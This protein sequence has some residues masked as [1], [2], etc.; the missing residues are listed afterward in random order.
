MALATLED[1]D[2][3]INVLY[4]GEGGSGKT[5]EAAYMALL[6]KIIMV[7]TESGIKKRPLRRLGLPIENI[8]PFRPMNYADVDKLYWQVKANL[9]KFEVGDPA[10]I[11]GVVFDSYTDLQKKFTDSV[12]ETRVGRQAATMVTDEFDIELKDHGKVTEQCRRIARRFR[13]LDCHTVF[14]TLAKRE[15]DTDGVI[16]RPD[17]TPKFAADMMGY[18]DAAIYTSQVDTP[19]Y[20][21]PSRFLGVTRPIGRYR[22]KDRYGALP[23]VFANPTFDR[24]LEYIQFEGEGGYQ[25]RQEIDQFQQA[26]LARGKPFLST[27]SAPIV[28]VEA[29]GET[30]PVADPEESK[31]VMPAI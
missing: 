9:D 10:R 29:S 23:P 26:Y 14:V 31:A 25:E 1:T 11:V 19:D 24:V 4:F 30:A 28:V 15:I 16:Y 6:G 3:F 21:D 27:P 5:T 18:V 7:D 12:V 13:D 17:L 22:G 2:E 8:V 20:E